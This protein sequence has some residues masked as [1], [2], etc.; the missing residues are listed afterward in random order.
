MNNKY[1]ISRILPPRE[2]LSEV[3]SL[4]AVAI[5][6]LQTKERDKLSENS[7]DFSLKR[8]ITAP[9]TKYGE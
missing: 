6:R 9:A 1:P 7:L 8:S 3:A 5:A 2:R 4:L